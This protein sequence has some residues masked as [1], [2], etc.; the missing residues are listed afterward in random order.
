MLYDGPKDDAVVESKPIEEQEPETMIP[1]D[2]KEAA[3]VSEPMTKEAPKSKSDDFGPQSEV[4]ITNLSAT[5][6]Q[7]LF[8]SDLQQMVNG[9]K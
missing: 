2:P 6:S 8:L 4:K 9:K 3:P 7:L 5:E 1:E